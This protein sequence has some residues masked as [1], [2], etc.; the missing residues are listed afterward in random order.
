VVPQIS[1]PTVSF[2]V[3]VYNAEDTLAASLASALE[4]THPAD[5]IVVINDGSRDGSG[6]VIATV[7]DP[8]IRAFIQPN[9]GLAATLNR[10]IDLAGSQYIA[11]LDNDDLALPQ[12]LERQLAFMEANPQVALLGTWSQIYVGDT[13]T[14]RFHRHP[15][16]SNSL[17]L[18]LLFDNP[19]VH[20]SV[21]YRTEVVRALG[22]YRVERQTRIPEDYEFWSRIAR[23]HDIAN[24]PEIHTIYREMPNS[25]T[26][27]SGP[28][29]LDNVIAISTDNLRH[30][31]PDASH[32]T[33]QGL[34]RLY[35]GRPA[36]AGSRM[37]LE[38]LRLWRQAAIA[39]G[40]PARQWTPEFRSCYRR[41]QR[42]LFTQIMRQCLPVP[43]ANLLRSMRRL[44]RPN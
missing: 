14:D 32:E 31:L 43:A 13:P 20:S 11:R 26:R 4:Q 21:M 22:G 9:Q 36:K 6:A 42:R 35:H 25:M 5:E 37:G 19:F 18:D 27:V 44:L 16:E 8:R 23:R 17:K 1:T 41:A 30:V 10:G 29:I 3:P 12:R 7:T 40:G 38:A 24:L 28:E 33:C 15:T 2:L 34:A 39:V